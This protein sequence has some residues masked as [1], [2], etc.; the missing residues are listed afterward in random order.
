MAF[1]SKSQLLNLNEVQTELQHRIDREVAEVG[2]ESLKAKTDQS[3]MGADFEMTDKLFGE[4]DQLLDES[5][6]VNSEK[7]KMKCDV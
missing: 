4:F 5:E 1:R 7:R 3:A 2:S 6:V